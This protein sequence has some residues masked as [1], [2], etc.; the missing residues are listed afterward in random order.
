MNSRAGACGS[1]MGTRVRHC[2][3]TT[4]T[5]SNTVHGSPLPRPRNS[6]SIRLIRL[7]GMVQSK[8]ANSGASMP[9]MNC[10]APAIVGGTSGSEPSNRT[11]VTDVGVDSPRAKA[12]RRP[13][14]TG[15]P[16]RHR[17]RRC[18]STRHSDDEPAAGEDG[19]LHQQQRVVVAAEPVVC[20]VDGEVMQ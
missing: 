4:V 15:P 3:S 12:R 20:V 2:H 8:M 5:A 14:R 17:R 16:S 1:E 9:V 11:G 13:T 6:S 10:C 18:D 7:Y 19:H